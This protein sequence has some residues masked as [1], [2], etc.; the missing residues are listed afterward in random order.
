MVSLCYT[1]I[2]RNLTRNPLTSLS[3]NITC[4]LPSLS[5]IDVTD[6]PHW[7]PN[8][9]LF[10]LRM[11]KTIIGWSHSPQ[12]TNCLLCRSNSTT[13]FE[14]FIFTRSSCVSRVYKHK[15]QSQFAHLL[16][17]TRFKFRCKYT[18]CC[19]R[20]QYLTVELQNECWSTALFAINCQSVFGYLAIIFNTVA[21]FQIL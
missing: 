2:H 8:W 6:I 9:E 10:Q 19:L 16:N 11:L 20:S 13:L 1:F 14:H 7:K 4:L 3:C 15:N 17:N 18:D 12:C 5:I 21:F